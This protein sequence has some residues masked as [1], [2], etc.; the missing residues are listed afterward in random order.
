[1]KKRVML[2][3][4]ALLLVVGVGAWA[5]GSQDTA[6]TAAKTIKYEDPE[7]L[8]TFDKYDPPIEVTFVRSAPPVATQ[9]YGE[10]EGPENNVWTKAY[11]EKLGIQI[12]YLW[13]V[14]ASQLETKTNLMMASGEIPDFLKTNLQQFSQLAEADLLEEIGPS[15]EKFATPNSRGLWN[16]A[17]PIIQAQ[18][19]V[20]GK[21][22][23]LP[24]AIWLEASPI[25]YVR[26]D[27]RQKLN[28]PE[29]KTMQ[30]VLDISKAFTE[31]DPDGN[32]KDDTVGLAIDNG[33]TLN[34]G[35]TS[36][37]AGFYESYHAYPGIWVKDESGKLVW[38]ATRPEM[39]NALKA[40]QDLYKAGQINKE[41]P[42]EDGNKV[43]E[44]LVS[45]KAGIFYGPYWTPLHPLQQGRNLDETMDWRAYPITSIDNNPAKIQHASVAGIFVV[46][47]KGVE[48]IEALFRIL[49]FGQRI[50]AS[51]SDE[52]YKKYI[53]D[54]DGG[55]Q[56]INQVPVSYGGS[57][58]NVDAYK[59]YIV[60]LFAGEITLDD[61]PPGQRSG[62]QQVK[63]FYDEGDNSMWCWARISEVGGALSVVR[64]YYD[65]DLHM[66]DAY[67]GPITD[68]IAGKKPI[69]DK[70]ELEMFTEIIL[71]A[72][73]STFDDFVEKW[74]EQG[75]DEMTEEVNAWYAVQPK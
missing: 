56:W 51:P 8:G 71:G 36:G 10:G 30:D 18:A 37:L 73:I 19:T 70:L 75:G 64:H 63:R 43:N 2:V 32:G 67:Y 33:L 42:T 44:M 72:P 11:F 20:D 29:P 28:L 41:F 27:W 40:L 22:L 52:I 49:D 31:R 4:L 3:S 61:V 24:H 15:F 9:K 1:M 14:D 68:T 5:A 12:K 16:R 34:V 60:P 74:Y 25:L 38:G 69:V 48:N 62:Y 54:G 35:N 46:A 65:N 55:E 47:R 58:L 17:G 6:T 57:M 39:K 66:P 26:E 7:G 59:E 45:G 13:I 50:N 23:G 53:N 21:V